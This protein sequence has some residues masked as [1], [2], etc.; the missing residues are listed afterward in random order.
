V[1]WLTGVN[2]GLISDSST[3]GHVGSPNAANPQVSGLVGDNS[4]MI[5]SPT[6]FFRPPPS[7]MC[8]L[9]LRRQQSAGRDY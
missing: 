6:A 2:Q 5:L 4:A 9:R 3:S 8:G 7:E 1:V